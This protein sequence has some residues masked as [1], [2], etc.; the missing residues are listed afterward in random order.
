MSWVM[1]YHH[2]NKLYRKSW[3]IKN[4]FLFSWNCSHH[5]TLSVDKWFEFP[6]VRC[7]ASRVVEYETPFVGLRT[8]TTSFFPD[9]CA[10]RWRSRPVSVFLE[11][12]CQMSASL[13]HIAH[14]TAWTSILI[15]SV[16]FLRLILQVVWVKATH[17]S[18]YVKS[19]SVTLQVPE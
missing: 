16:T 17:T 18:T 10:T 9:T 13:A 1:M 2:N 11:A 14:L 4:W 15:N 6:D 19:W 8:T 12:M 5:F 3:K 7:F